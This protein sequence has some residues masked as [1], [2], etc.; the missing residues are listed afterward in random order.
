MTKKTKAVSRIDEMLLEAVDDEL[1][2]G[3]TAEMITVR[4]LGKEVP[5]GGTELPAADSEE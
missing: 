1:V 5:R 4:V 2:S 3:D